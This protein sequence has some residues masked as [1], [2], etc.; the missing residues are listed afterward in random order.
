MRTVES[1]EKTLMLVKIRGQQEK[2]VKEDETAGWHHQFNGYELG[3][4]PGD[5]EGQVAL[6][7]C[8][9]WGCEGLDITW[10]LNNNNSNQGN[11]SQNSAFT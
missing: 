6:A 2:E 4:T 7:G 10:Q 11:S 1:L 5:G 3:Q 9:P 8:S